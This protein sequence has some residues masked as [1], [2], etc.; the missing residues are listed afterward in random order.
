[1][2]ITNDQLNNLRLSDGTPVTFVKVTSKDNIQVRLP[3]S[4]AFSDGDPLK[5]FKRDG[6]HYKGLTDL[7]LVATATAAAPAA[8]AAAQISGTFDVGGMFFSNLDE[9]KAEAMD[10]FLNAAATAK[11]YTRQAV[12]K[13]GVLDL[14]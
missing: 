2:N 5:I 13:V 4:H 7:T 3:D 10:L 11:I 1:M 14:V 8:P 12:A 9:A 6:T